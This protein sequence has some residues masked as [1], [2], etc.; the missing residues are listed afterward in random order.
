MRNINHLCEAQSHSFLIL[1]SPFLW[2]WEVRTL[3][4][5][6][7]KSECVNI[8]CIRDG[9]FL[10]KLIC[11]SS[12]PCR[13]SGKLCCS[14]VVAARSLS[15]VRS[16]TTWTRKLANLNSKIGQHYVC[17]VIA[18]VTVGNLCMLVLRKLEDSWF[19]SYV[20]GIIGQETWGFISYMM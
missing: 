9:I 11:E 1:H 12:L 5:D 8:V 2:I 10:R 17:R 15:S 6:K 13:G 3:C 20:S 19:I 16:V 7:H 18:V 14:M 4:L